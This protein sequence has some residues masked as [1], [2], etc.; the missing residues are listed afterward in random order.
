MFDHHFSSFSLLNNNQIQQ[1][2]PSFH[3]Q[4]SPV[5]QTWREPHQSL[6][7]PLSQGSLGREGISNSPSSPTAVRKHLLNSVLDTIF[8][9]SDC[10]IGSFWLYL[11]I[12]SGRSDQPFEGSRD[13]SQEEQRPL[14]GFK[15]RV[16]Y[17]TT[18]SKIWIRSGC[19]C[20]IRNKYLY[21]YYT[22]TI[23]LKI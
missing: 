22:F 10:I 17:F 19:C 12:L 16:L 4:P 13:A 3:E 11:L 18:A 7:P 8:Y 1:T 2:H 14:R 20:G 5:W 6:V 21:K 9:L 23:P 15:S